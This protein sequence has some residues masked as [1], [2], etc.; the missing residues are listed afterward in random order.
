MPPGAC[1]C[2]RCDGRVYPTEFPRAVDPNPALSFQEAFPYLG[3][4]IRIASLGHKRAIRLVR[5]RRHSG[6]YAV[7]IRRD[8]QTVAEHRFDDIR[9]AEQ[10]FD[11]LVRGEAL[12]R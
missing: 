7:E 11:A 4:V 6:A 8:F 5:E 1:T 10:V 12:P 9:R 3:R 2:G